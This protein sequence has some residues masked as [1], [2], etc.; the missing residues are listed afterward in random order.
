[1]EAKIESFR[2]GRHTQTTN[3]LILTV[4][5]IDKTK[6]GS[7]IGK[8]VSWKSPT[9]KEIKGEIKATHGSKGAVRALFDKGIPGQAIG[10]KVSIQ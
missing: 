7:L 3:Q 6:A 8:K 10:Q 5:N 9:G 4:E 2:R 1:M